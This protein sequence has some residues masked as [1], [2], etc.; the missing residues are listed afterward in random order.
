MSPQY[1][2]WDAYTNGVPTGLRGISF[3]VTVIDFVT[4]AGYHEWDLEILKVNDG[5]ALYNASYSYWITELR[6]EKYV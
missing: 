1:L 5:N 6:A 2:Y 3:T 4:E